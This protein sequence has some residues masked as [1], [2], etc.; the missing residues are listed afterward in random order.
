MFALLL[1]PLVLIFMNTLTTTLAKTGAVDPDA[2][3]VPILQLIGS[4]PV[5]LMIT[6]L[7]SMW[8]LGTRRGQTRRLIEDM[9][10]NALKPIAPVL[11]VTG[12]GGMFSAVLIV[13]GIGDALADTLEATGLPLVAAVFLIT[14]IMRIALGGTTIA[15]T[16]AAGLLGASIVDA[17]LSPVQTAAVVLVMAGGSAVLPHVNDASFWLVG[18]LL[19]MNVIQ[20]LKTWTVLKTL[21]GTIGALFASAIFYLA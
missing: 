8:A 1:L 5:A 11:L 20:T 14:A 13:S 10:D 19:G 9:L 7:A 16:T 12:A 4:I 17:G 3:W 15:I 18:R 2:T 21:L 6:V